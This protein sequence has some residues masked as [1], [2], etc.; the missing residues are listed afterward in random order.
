MVSPCPRPRRGRGRNPAEEPGNQIAMVTVMSRPTIV[1]GT[2]AVPLLM[3]A[4][5]TP[6]ALAAR[7]TASP[8]EAIVVN[9]GVVELETASSAGHFVPRPRD[10]PNPHHYRATPP[11][12]P[13]LS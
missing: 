1:A 12:R 13:P 3:A 2:I 6:A 10:P 8:P 7:A 5:A 4:L 11:H 9:R